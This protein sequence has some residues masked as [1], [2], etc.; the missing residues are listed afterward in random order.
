M[1]RKILLLALGAA[2]ASGGSTL[3]TTSAAAGVTY[4][5][6][7]VADCKACKEMHPESTC[8][9]AAMPVKPQDRVSKFVAPGS[10]AGPAKPALAKPA[11]KKPTTLPD[12]SPVS[13]PSK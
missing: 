10:T 6:T 11:P 12:G 7:T 9:T 4:I 1:N 5:C 3:L 8:Q 2:L 13:Y